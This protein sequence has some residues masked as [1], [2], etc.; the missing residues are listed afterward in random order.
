RV[1][2]VGG[3]EQGRLAIEVALLEADASFRQRYTEAIFLFIFGNEFDRDTAVPVGGGNL[4][5]VEGVAPYC[6]DAAALQQVELF[7]FTVADRARGGER[8]QVILEERLLDELLWQGFLWRAR[9]AWR[10]GEPPRGHRRRR[11]NRCPRVAHP[12]DVAGN[13]LQP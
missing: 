13:Q 4:G 5:R 1:V 9:R 6:P 7:V 12:V 10:V 2:D 11:R 8:V 3:A